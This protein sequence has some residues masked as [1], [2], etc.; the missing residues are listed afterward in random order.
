MFR[1]KIDISRRVNSFIFFQSVN[2]ILPIC[3][4]KRAY[5]FVGTWSASLDSVRVRSTSCMIWQLSANLFVDS[6]YVIQRTPK[7]LT[8]S[9]WPMYRY[10][11]HP[12]GSVSYLEHI[13][14][15]RSPKGSG[16]NFSRNNKIATEST[17]KSLVSVAIYF[18][19]YLRTLIGYRFRDSEI[20]SE[21]QPPNMLLYMM[22]HHPMQQPIITM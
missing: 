8:L 7:V 11:S 15:I 6:C 4:I 19:K 12:S 13:R 10:V 5:G 1:N 21:Q 9:C 18:L 16:R 3:S 17:I 22:V 20:Y 14:K 2:R